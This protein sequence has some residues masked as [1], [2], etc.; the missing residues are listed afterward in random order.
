MTT[1]PLE[2]R[3]LQALGKIPLR[4]QALYVGHGPGQEERY[5]LAEIDALVDAL[6]PHG[7]LDG[8]VLSLWPG[9]SGSDLRSRVRQAVLVFYRNGRH[10]VDMDV[11]AEAVLDR[12]ADEKRVEE[13]AWG[14][15]PDKHG[16]EGDPGAL[17]DSLARH[18][19][20]GGH[21]EHGKFAA[22]LAGF[23]PADVVEELWLLTVK[24]I[25]WANRPGLTKDEKKRNP[26]YPQLAS[27]L[28]E[29][30]LV[31][32]DRVLALWSGGY[33]VSMYAQERGY[34]TLE[35]TRAGKVYDQLK[36]FKN[37]APL[38]ELWNQISKQ[39]VVHGTPE[40]HIFV[41]SYDPSCVLYTEELPT[42]LKLESVAELRW[43][44][45]SGK[46]LEELTEL[47]AD[48]TPVASYAFDNYR[49]VVALMPP[50]AIRNDDITKNRMA[51]ELSDHERQQ[52]KEDVAVDRTIS[53]GVEGMFLK[54]VAAWVG[55][56]ELDQSSDDSA[57]ELQEKREAV[58]AIVKPMVTRVRN[59]ARYDDMRADLERKLG[60]L[61][62]RM[63]AKY[64]RSSTVRELQRYAADSYGSGWE[65]AA[66]VG[67]AML[68]EGRSLE[69]AKAALDAMRTPRSATQ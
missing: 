18:A 41:R 12:L 8:R 9:I 49:D 61:A 40:V 50:D 59:G 24:G 14:G 11:L 30:L 16:G 1:T 21:P 55:T 27:L 3:F 17:A 48:G 38:G 13:V 69:E 25:D 63:D 62:R 44:L 32:P 57:A 5:A 29:A 15:D 35:T 6:V 47:N 22:A 19:D 36:L 20:T 26:Y 43:H 64:P 58:E 2:S 37:W 54:E 56:Y 45:L 66:D 23:L 53:A 28:R 68:R 52:M 67:I 31:P 4:V 42:I 51:K 39:F 7:G 46:K 65:P 33:D 10:F 60:D 34:F